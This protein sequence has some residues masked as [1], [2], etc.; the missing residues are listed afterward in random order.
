MCGGK[1]STIY[2]TEDGIILWQGSL[3]ACQ[4]LMDFSWAFGMS[5]ASG[6]LP[7][8]AL[9]AA[10]TGA[11]HLR[12]SHGHLGAT[13]CTCT[14]A[15]HAQ[16]VHAHPVHCRST[17]TRT[18]ARAFLPCSCTGRTRSPCTLLHALHSL[19]HMLI[20]PSCTCGL[21]VRSCPCTCALCTCALPLSHT[22]HT[23]QQPRA[24]R[25]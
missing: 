4:L 1:G 15:L 22:L 14:H 23:H 10:G 12:A 19:A 7:W 13:R 2:S 17:C 3:C 18:P 6:V 11:G 16:H 21:R 8:R 5:E 25:P 20:S 24:P 9:V